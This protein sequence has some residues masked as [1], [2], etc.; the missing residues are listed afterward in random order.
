MCSVHRTHIQTYELVPLKCMYREIEFT[1]TQVHT[2][3]H[4]HTHHTHTHTHT[5]IHTHTH[6]HTHTPTHTYI[7]TQTHTHTYTHI[8]RHTQMHTYTDTDTRTQTHTHRHTCVGLFKQSLLVYTQSVLG[9]SLLCRV[10]QQ[11]LTLNKNACQTKLTI[12]K[13]S[14]LLIFQQEISHDQNKVKN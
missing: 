14:S 13:W 11:N 2:H 7:Y 9:E 1:H 12:G 8:H 3:R 5:H 6:T 10:H 4:T